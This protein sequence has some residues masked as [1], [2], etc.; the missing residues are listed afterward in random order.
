MI[1]FA[2]VW[3][4][5]GVDVTWG[6]KEVGGGIKIEKFGDHEEVLKAFGFQSE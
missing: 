2:R 4:W 1:E 6:K 5:C 3:A